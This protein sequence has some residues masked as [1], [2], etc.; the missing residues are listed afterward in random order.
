MEEEGGGGCGRW[1]GS[2]RSETVPGRR[3][4]GGLFR[5]MCLLKN[6]PLC[7]E[8]TSSLDPDKALHGAELSHCAR[9]TCTPFLVQTDKQT[10]YC[11]QFDISRI[12]DKEEYTQLPHI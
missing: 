1:G 7:W 3:V 4:G 9:T 8:A 11:I 10:L 2:N 6:A 5:V 12:H